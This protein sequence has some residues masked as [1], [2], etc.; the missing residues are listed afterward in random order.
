MY[1]VWL[2]LEDKMPSGTPANGARNELPGRGRNVI[3]VKSWAQKNCWAC[4]ADPAPPYYHQ[5]LIGWRKP[6][7]CH[8]TITWLPSDRVHASVG[9]LPIVWL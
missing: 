4:N 7:S 9:Q 1:D 3:G 2:P 6:V 8:A 5:A